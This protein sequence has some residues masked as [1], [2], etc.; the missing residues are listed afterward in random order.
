M[1]R[2]E[3]IAYSHLGECEIP[4]IVHL[5]AE[6]RRW[7]PPCRN[8]GVPVPDDPNPRW[9]AAYSAGEDW[10]GQLE[11]S[12]INLKIVESEKIYR[13]VIGDLN[14]FLSG[15]EI[16]F[17]VD[18]V[19]NRLRVNVTRPRSSWHYLDELSAGEHQVLILVYLLIRRLEKGGVA[20]I[21]EPDLHIHP[22]LISS[23]LSRIEGITRE[24][25]GQLIITSHIPEIWDRYETSGIRVSLGGAS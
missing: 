6:E 15:K 14:R 16:D 7:I 23:L 10:K 8:I 3:E 1:E 9:L 11:A 13:D 21:D 25:N 19:E 4:N 22:S 24:R 17:K 5:D 12:L 20:L 18:P 2:R